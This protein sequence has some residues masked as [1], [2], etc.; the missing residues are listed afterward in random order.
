MILH[1]IVS[2]FVT[3]KPRD[4]FINADLL[5]NET[6]V[7]GEN[8]TFECWTFGAET[9]EWVRSKGCIYD[10]NE[11]SNVTKL[12]VID[13]LDCYLGCHMISSHS[14]ADRSAEFPYI[15]YT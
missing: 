7:V 6:A 14:I 3:L 9:I 15:A 12:K 10:D 11:T 2:T 13:V 1:W 4:P 8:V 5:K